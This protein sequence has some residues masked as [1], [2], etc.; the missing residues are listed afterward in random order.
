LVD[1]SVV[2]VLAHLTVPHLTLFAVHEREPVP[3]AKVR[4]LIEFLSGYFGSDPYW[5]RAIAD[6]AAHRPDSQLTSA[7]AS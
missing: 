3:S 6:A 1:G 2:P 7:P 4:L 5:D